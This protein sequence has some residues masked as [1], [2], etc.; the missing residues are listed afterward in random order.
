MPSSLTAPARML[1]IAAIVGAFCWNTPANAIDLMDAWRAAQAWDSTYAAAKAALRVALEKIP[2]GDAI[3]APHVDLTVNATEAR[4][5]YRSGDANAKPSA[6]SQGQQLGAAVVLSQP[7][8]DAAGAVARDRLHR[9]AEQAHIVFEQARQDL[10]LRVSRAYFDLLLAGDNLQLA[11]AQKQAISE[12]VGLAKQSYELGLTSVTD[13]DD[14]QA[15]YDNV[16]AAEQAARTDVAAKADVVRQLTAYEP[17]R[18]APVSTRVL[19]VKP[20]ELELNSMVDHARDGNLTSRQLALG[21]QIAHR[22]IDQY[23]LAASPIVSVVASY[24]NQLAAGTI[25]ASGGRDRTGSAAVG[26]QLSMP[27]WDGGSRRSLQR[28]AVAFEDQQAPGLEGSRRDAERLARTYASTVRD[29]AQR[30]AS[31]DRARASG[32]NSVESNKVGREAG[33]RTTIDVLNAEQ[34]WY[35]TLTLL[36]AARYDFLFAQLQLAATAGDLDEARLS[37]VNAALVNASTSQP[38]GRRFDLRSGA[39][40][41]AGHRRQEHR[42]SDGTS[43]RGGLDAGPLQTAGHGEASEAR[44]RHDAERR[45]G[46]NRRLGRPCLV[47]RVLWCVGGPY[48]GILNRIRS[49]PARPLIPQRPGSRSRYFHCRWT[50]CVSPCHI[51]PRGRARARG[52]N[53][54]PYAGA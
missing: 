44:H 38:R 20:S 24:G 54:H 5:D 21:V 16:E 41:G 7:I 50:R 28:Q 8:Y 4:Q 32:A 10:M 48:Q 22:Q 23:R 11:V 47:E 52:V 26:L 33:V 27:L 18:L 31:L 45:Y 51:D 39:W 19:D 29:G 3:L 25:S 30:V 42:Q 43:A 6:V 40:F 35:Q 1:R 34:A 36:S 37:R 15:R 12:Q 14:A 2:Q 9:E 13:A 17:D 49:V 53:W 46:S